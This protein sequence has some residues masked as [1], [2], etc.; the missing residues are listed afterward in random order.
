MQMGFPV[1][2]SK[3]LH[4]HINFCIRMVSNNHFKPHGVGWQSYK[5]FAVMRLVRYTSKYSEA[6]LV[7]DNDIEII[8]QLTCE[9][10]GQHYCWQH[11]DCTL[12]TNDQSFQRKN[13]LNLSIRQWK[14][15]AKTKGSNVSN[16]QPDWLSGCER[17]YVFFVW[18]SSLF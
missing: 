14:L 18:S 16:F 2:D 10:F 5:W 3:F 17:V 4:V 1:S 13:M 15:G 11:A 9:S 6:T 8:I 7:M 12:L